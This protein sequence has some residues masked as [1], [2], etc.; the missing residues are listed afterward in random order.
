V[1]RRLR[2]LGLAAAL[3]AG[4]TAQPRPRALSYHPSDAD[5]SVTRIVHSSVI[6]EMRRT[7]FII[8]P[9]FHS[10]LVT[11][12]TEALGLIPEGLPAAAAVL[13]THGHPD[14]FD[15]Q[16]LEAIAR[17]T[18]RVV[19]PP[20]LHAR[21]AALG[22]TRID[23]LRWGEEVV[24]DGI[25]VHAVPASHA[26]REN[27]YVLDGGGVSLYDAGDTRYSDQLPTIAAAFPHLDVALLP[28]GGLRLL[29]LPR[30]MSPEDAARAAELLAPRKVIPIGY[31]AGGGT[32]IWWRAGSPLDR[33]IAACAER[34]IPRSRIVV[35]EP[36]ESW[37]LVA[38]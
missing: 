30:E 11:R 31:G 27:G 6:V 8:D 13:I 2:V 34:G 25:T 12:Q 26:V 17:T 32:P 15:P 7:R 19:A 3:A 4:C 5:L 16:V 23:D 1:I 10:G 14:H 24:V 29:G 33:F 22:F 28:I 35:L 38:R 18:P 9:W 36:G 21:L 20:E 37:H